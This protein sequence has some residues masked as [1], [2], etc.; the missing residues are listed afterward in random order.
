MN[1]EPLQVVWQWNSPTDDHVEIYNEIINKAELAE[2]VLVLCVLPRG[3]CCRKMS[4]CPSVTRRF[5]IETAERVNQTV[6][7]SSSH[8]I[9]V[10]HTGA[11]N[12]GDVKHYRVNQATYSLSS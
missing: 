4:V 11:S 3:M 6:S 2:V 12:A 10:F 5:C 1:P 9:L 7:P 8:T